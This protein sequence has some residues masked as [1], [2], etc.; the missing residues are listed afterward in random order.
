[1][2]DILKQM[3]SGTGGFGSRKKFC[4]AAFVAS[5]VAMVASIS[6][7]T[8]Q[9]MAVSMASAGTMMRTVKI[10][11]QMYRSAS[12]RQPLAVRSGSRSQT[13]GA[14]QVRPCRYIP[15]GIDTGKSIRLRGKGMPGIGKGAR[16]IC[17]CV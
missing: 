7:E 9:A 8:V 15:A 6:T 14:A 16:A 17:C 12:M 13:A 2:D 10:C 5:T 1:M 4:S 11:M 3:F